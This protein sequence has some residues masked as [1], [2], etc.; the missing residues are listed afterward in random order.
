MTR[1]T[2]ALT[3]FISLSLAV[4]VTACGHGAGEP[5]EPT[6]PSAAP[7]AEVPAAPA[8]SAA[9]AAPSAAAPAE[10]PPAPS[11]APATSGAPEPA[12]SAAPAK[13]GKGKTEPAGHPAKATPEPAPV[14][15][16][17]AP[18]AGDA[19]AAD[20]CTTKNF[21]Y[22][23]LGAAC[24]SGGRKAAKEVMKGVVKKAKAAGTDLKCTSCHVDMNSF[25][26]KGNAVSDLKQWL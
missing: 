25:Q 23:Q 18:P 7:A 15:S 16:A 24:H 21:H 2:T 26:L 4:A 17:S 20:A 9:E 5:A 22:S 13:P 14:A 10:A 3:A 12:A 1:S 8:P 19:P 6:A 11:A